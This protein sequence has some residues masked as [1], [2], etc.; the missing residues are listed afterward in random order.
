M[1]TK[2]V[3]ISFIFIAIQVN[4]AAVEDKLVGCTSALNPFGKEVGVI[5][6]VMVFF[7]VM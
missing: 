4:P 7:M 6:I 2:P 3:I 1:N 5:A